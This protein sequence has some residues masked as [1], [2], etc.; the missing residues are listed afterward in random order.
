MRVPPYNF[1]EICCTRSVTP[2][3]S[4]GRRDDTH[5]TKEVALELPRHWVARR[6]EIDCLPFHHKIGHLSLRTTCRESRM[7]DDRAEHGSSLA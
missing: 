3:R 7:E 4:H 2:C 5:G 1:S 6:D